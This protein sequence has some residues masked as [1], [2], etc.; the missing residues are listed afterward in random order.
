VTRYKTAHV[1]A[2]VS[3][4]A[5]IAA[6]V[7]HLSNYRRVVLQA[8]QGISGLAPLVATLWL[9]FAGAMLVL[10]GIVSLV[11][12]RWVRGGRWVLAFAG[13]FPLITVF[14]QLQ[15]LGFTRATAMLTAVAAVSFVAALVYPGGPE[16]LAAGAA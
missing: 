15:L 14:L 1:L 11:A 6:A 12:L 13:C 16:P 10:G 7:M 4:L 2:A 3:A 8:Q 9:A 5:F